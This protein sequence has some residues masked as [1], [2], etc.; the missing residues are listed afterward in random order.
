ML[1][2]KNLSFDYPD[3][4]FNHRI[5]PLLHDVCFG[6]KSGSMLHLRGNNGSGKTT[7]LKLLA[8]LVPPLE[9]TIY[10]RGQCVAKQLAMYQEQLCY[11]G[12][13]AGIS[14]AL[15]V[16]ENCRFDLQYA[17]S[18]ST[19][20]SGLLRR[21]SLYELKDVPCHV[22]SAGQRRRVGLLRL[23]LSNAKLWL[24]DEPLVALDQDSIEILM[25]CLNE[26]VQKGGGVVL[27][28]H[29]RLP[30]DMRDYQEYCL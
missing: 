17:R 23:M 4:G 16:L 14:Q 26:H 22:L 21:F 5:A 8:G 3:E 29:Q 27:T 30:L 13:K 18:D 19:V 28:S 7:L 10:Y 2:L 24:L 9:G 12:H 11:V 1:E 15:T 20:L 6:L 25:V